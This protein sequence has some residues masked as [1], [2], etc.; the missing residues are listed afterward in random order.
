MKA[1]ASEEPPVFMKIIFFST[2]RVSLTLPKRNVAFLNI[3]IRFSVSPSFASNSDQEC[4]VC[5]RTS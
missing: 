1:E 4:W 5:G 3:R 2:L